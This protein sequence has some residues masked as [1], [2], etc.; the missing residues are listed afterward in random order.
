[1]P[2][3]PDLCGGGGF[4]ID[5]RMVLDD[6]S[7]GQVVFDSRDGQGKGIVLATGKQGTIRIDF[8]D[9]TTTSGWGCDS[10]LL[11]CGTEHHITAIVDGGPKI[12]TFV[13]DGVLCDGGTRRQYGWG[14]FNKELG[15][16]NGSGEF[17]IA[18]SLRGKLKVLRIY[19][20]YLRTSE[21]VANFHAHGTG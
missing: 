21:A 16:V 13:I 3:L 4:S 12:V 6:L 20:R 18:P 2:P 8:S 1:M 7:P 5:L 14:R 19:D 9:G 15:D 11:G 17:R 10:D